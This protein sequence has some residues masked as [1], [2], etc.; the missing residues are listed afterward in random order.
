MRSGVFFFIA[1]I[2]LAQGCSSSSGRGAGP[3]SA[4]PKVVVPISLETQQAMA[5]KDTVRSTD[6]WQVIQRLL[7]ESGYSPGKADGIPGRKTRAAIKAYQKSAK[8]PVTGFVTA[9][10]NRKSKTKDG[11]SQRSANDNAQLSVS[12]LAGEWAPTQIWETKSNPV[13]ELKRSESNVIYHF[14][15]TGSSQYRTSKIY[16]NSSDSADTTRLTVSIFLPM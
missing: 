8:L 9:T 4:V 13:K 11:I 12:N 3:V 2:L 6:Q 1:F 16:R 15:K 10:M 5:E 14:E 7:Q